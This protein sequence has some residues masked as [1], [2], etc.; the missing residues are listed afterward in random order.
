MKN[1]SDSL[2]HNPRGHDYKL[3]SKE[4]S[5]LGVSFIIYHNIRRSTSHIMNE[6]IKYSI[7]EPI[8]YILHGKY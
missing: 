2:S 3:L 1:I 4:L 7:Q 6:S 8:K 5:E